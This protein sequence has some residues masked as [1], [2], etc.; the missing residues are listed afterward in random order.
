MTEKYRKL[1][2][3]GGMPQRLIDSLL[4]QFH[5]CPVME[6]QLIRVARGTTVKF[7]SIAESVCEGSV[8][9]MTELHWILMS[10][11]L[12]V[13]THYKTEDDKKREVD[14]YSAI[15]NLKKQLARQSGLVDYASAEFRDLL[16]YCK[17]SKFLD[18]M[19][20]AGITGPEDAIVGSPTMFEMLD[21]LKI[22]VKNSIESVE[23]YYGITD[24]SLRPR[25]KRRRQGAGEFEWLVQ[26][27]IEWFLQF[28]S[29]SPRTEI[30]QS[31]EKLFLSDNGE[32]AESVDLSSIYRAAYRRVK[33][34]QKKNIVDPRTLQYRWFAYRG[35]IKGDE[36]ASEKLTFALE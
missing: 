34:N 21:C 6:K 14:L 7:W 22:A 25:Y 31:A 26:Q 8:T 18:H 11:G 27:I 13:H 12:D 15:D 28:Q 3:K 5:V 10:G 16:P 33:Q 35:T 19:K 30:L 1:A 29:V 32:L 2:E 4:V 20:E 9:H 24:H 17:N 23:E 36:F